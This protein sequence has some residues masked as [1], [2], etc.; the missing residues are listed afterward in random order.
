MRGIHTPQEIRVPRLRTLKE[1]T[2]GNSGPSWW[3]ILQDQGEV[4]QERGICGLLKCEV[5]ALRG[6]GLGLE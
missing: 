3:L 2:A 6:A 1:T 4:P 5:G